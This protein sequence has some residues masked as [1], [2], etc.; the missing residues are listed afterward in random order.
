MTGDDIE[1]NVNDQEATT[2]TSNLN[3]LSSGMQ[4]AQNFVTIFKIEAMK[5]DIPLSLCNAIRQKDLCSIYNSDS[6]KHAFGDERDKKCPLACPKSIPMANSQCC[7]FFF[8][9]ID[10]CDIHMT[11]VATDSYSRLATNV[12]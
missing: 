7:Y 10:F 6:K 4:R 5:C 1:T 12:T 8:V 2:R 11:P 9:I 3:I